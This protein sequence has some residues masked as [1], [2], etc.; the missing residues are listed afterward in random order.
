MK[1]KAKSW[2]NMYLK[3]STSLLGAVRPLVG[4][5]AAVV[6]GVAFPGVRYAAAIVTLELRGAARNIDAASLV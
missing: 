6:F 4:A 3:V 2:S 5:V 1:W